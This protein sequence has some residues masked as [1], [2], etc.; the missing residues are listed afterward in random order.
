MEFRITQAPPN[1]I[2]KIESK[3]HRT[4]IPLLPTKLKL[5][6]EVQN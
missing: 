5:K 6:L 1:S 3:L 4:V 2:L